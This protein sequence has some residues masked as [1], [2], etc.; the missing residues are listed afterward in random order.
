MALLIVLTTRIDSY[1]LSPAPPSPE[2]VSPVTTPSFSPIS[3]EDPATIDRRKLVGVG[4]L[5]TPRWGASPATH[6]RTPS[7]PNAFGPS[8]PVQST[9]STSVP[10]RGWARGQSGLGLGVGVGAMGDVKEETRDNRS[11]HHSVSHATPPRPTPPVSAPPQGSDLL[12]QIPDFDFDSNM[13]AALAA[14]LGMTDDKITPPRAAREHRISAPPPQ[15]TSAPPL[16]EL[17]SQQIHQGP[18]APPKVSPGSARSRIYARRASRQASNTEG[19]PAATAPTSPIYSKFATTSPRIDQSFRQSSVPPMG[20]LD[21]PSR[22]KDDSPKMSRFVEEPYVPPRQASRRTPP[23]SADSSGPL[24]P[25]SLRRKP[26]S[27]KSGDGTPKSR[28]SPNGSHHEFLK[29]FAPKDFS[30]L[31]PSPSSASINQFL[32]NSGSIHNFASPGGTTGQTS[33]FMPSSSSKTSLQRSD[34][35][36]VRASKSGWEG[37]EPG[38]DASEALRK[39]DGLSNTPNK[40]RTP[41][42]KQ[43]TGAQSASSRPGTPPPSKSRP[44]QTEKKLPSKPSSA[45]LRAEAGDSPLQAWIDLAGDDIPDVPAIPAPASNRRRSLK[46]F[47][48]G[49]ST[50]TEVPALAPTEKRESTS[51]T[52]F[53]GTPTSRD[54]TSLPTS[55]TPPTSTSGIRFDKGGR[56]TSGGSEASAHSEVS[57]D[58]ADKVERSVPPVPPLPKS[59]MSLRQGISTAVQPTTYD[60]PQDKTQEATSQDVYSPK[61][62]ISAVP[63]ESSAS[64]PSHV[65]VTDEHGQPSTSY[66]SQTGSTRRPRMSKKWSFSSALNL[67]RHSKD[68]SAPL[69]S[70]SMWDISISEKVPDTRGSQTPWTEIEHGEVSP[71]N[72]PSTGSGGAETRSNLSITPV[73]TNLPGPAPLP[74]SASKR[75]TPSSLPFFRRTS[76]SSIASKPSLPRPEDVPGPQ[77]RPSGLS[78]RQVSNVMEPVDEPPREVPATPAQPK[79]SVLGML[80]GSVSKRVVS[81]KETSIGENGEVKEPVKAASTGWAGRKRGKVSLRVDLS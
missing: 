66:A 23:S 18:F 26:G 77:R 70:P 55:S 25:G 35:G 73:A 75:L 19:G 3:P 34:S 58:G 22:A 14:S 2:R 80:R 30:H 20:D 49:E 4:E 16:P 10:T 47:L 41:K 46:G 57:A 40:S 5:S 60:S 33:Y 74:R 65:S 12:A 45:S 50:T 48:T 17:R 13:T 54:S 61:S 78:D 52:S 8:L 7:I 9:P 67:A 32:R 53:V 76:S 28:Q 42:A 39:L 24:P 79:K 15:T 21:L 71:T 6:S 1:Y 31:P 36:R 43:S 62:T 38:L 68:S 37:Q 59:Y 29:Q 27:N 64:Q 63:S 51:S 69:S 56:R 44:P 72:V 11:R 81:N